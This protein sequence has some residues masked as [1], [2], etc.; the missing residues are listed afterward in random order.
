MVRLRT[1]DQFGRV[2]LL[3][4]AYHL[5][6]IISCLSS[7]GEAVRKELVRIDCQ[8]WMTHN[9]DQYHASGVS[10]WKRKPVIDHAFMHSESWALGLEKAEKEFKE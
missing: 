6:L 3:Q 1:V 5:A 7:H 10:T 4:E 9:S 2:K 8:L